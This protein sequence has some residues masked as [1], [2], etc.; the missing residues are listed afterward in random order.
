MARIIR[1]EVYGI[2]PTHGLVE[3]VKRN[4]LDNGTVADL[5]PRCAA[6]GGIR[7]RED[8]QRSYVKTVVTEVRRIEIVTRS[9]GAAPSAC[10][11]RCT[12]GKRSCDC[13]C[14]GRCHGAG[15]CYCVG[16]K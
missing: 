10:G 13:K 2:C 9:G 5:C 7:I 12:S 14:G 1:H 3:K 6:E 15:R 16:V 8:G 4:T 11:G